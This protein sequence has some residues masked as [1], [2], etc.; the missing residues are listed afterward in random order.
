M[1]LETRH[2]LR[3]WVDHPSWWPRGSLLIVQASVADGR[4][5]WVEHPIGV[6]YEY[7]RDEAAVAAHTREPPRER[8]TP[9]LVSLNAWT[10]RGRRGKAAVNR[11][12]VLR[13]LRAN[14]WANTLLPP[15]TFIERL[16]SARFVA[17][18]EGNGV[19]THRVYEALATGAVPVVED[20]R[21]MRH[22]LRGLPV[23]WTRDYAELTPA[24]LQTAYATM[25]DTEYDFSR[26]Y[27]STYD[28]HTQATMRQLGDHWCRYLLGRPY[29]DVAA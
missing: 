15:R 26:L 19:D 21:G 2:T 13:N 25:L 9:L 28:A 8:A 11:D 18:P 12:V 22:K 24:Y 17:A 10:D 14:G 3:E 29:Y 5:T 27:M 16:R 7:V 20:H 23:L 4:D 6:S 1:A